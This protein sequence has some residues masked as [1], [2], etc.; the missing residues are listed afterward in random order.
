M[1]KDKKRNSEQTAKCVTDTHTIT[2]TETD[3]T[4]TMNNG[5]NIQRCS[6]I[7]IDQEVS[8]Q[9]LD[10]GSNQQEHSQENNDIEIIDVCECTSKE[11]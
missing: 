11:F 1:Q 4:R 10:H 2:D 5:Q 3:T 9:N 7:N 8:V 6:W